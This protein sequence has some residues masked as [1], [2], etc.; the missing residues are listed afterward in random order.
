MGPTG[1]GKNN[2][3]KGGRGKKKVS[4]SELK[5]QAASKEQHDINMETDDKGQQ[6]LDQIHAKAV[7][8]IL[9]LQLEGDDATDG[10]LRTSSPAHME[11]EDLSSVKVELEPKKP[12]VKVDD[13]EEYVSKIKAGWTVDDANT[14][15]LGELY[16]MVS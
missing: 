13:H 15:T 6:N 2:C 16:I 9:S 12:E 8:K 5:K 3:A 4:D 11:T 1:K 10:D 7:E 14:L